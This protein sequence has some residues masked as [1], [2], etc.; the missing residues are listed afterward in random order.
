MTNIDN[1]MTNIDNN[2]TTNI[3]IICHEP[4]NSIELI[5]PCSC[6]YPKHR[7][8]LDKWIQYAPLLFKKKCEIC[9]TKY[10]LKGPNNINYIIKNLNNNH[11]HY[12]IDTTTMNCL[13]KCYY[14]LGIYNLGENSRKYVIAIILIN[15]MSFI[16]LIKIIT[17]YQF[18]LIIFF[19]IGQSLLIN[20]LYKISINLS[21]RSRVIPQF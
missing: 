14:Y 16:I 8:C 1:N 9:L 17:R 12:L 7:L 15:F 3:C 2:M 13:E 19:F 10:K 18:I 21:I 20:I 6:H 5:Y 11:N 4:V